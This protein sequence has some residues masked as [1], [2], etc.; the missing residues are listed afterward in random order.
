MTD[1]GASTILMEGAATMTICRYYLLTAKD[2][3]IDEL[4]SALVALAGRVKTISGCEGVELYRDSKTRVRF[5][6]IERW[7]SM[8]AHRAAGQLLG[9]DAFAPTMATVVEPPV[10]AYWEPVALSD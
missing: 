1:A 7:T 8:D 10:S 2:A 9:K 5:H 4:Q 6:F 3:S